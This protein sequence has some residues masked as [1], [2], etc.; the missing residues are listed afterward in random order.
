M[1][2]HPAM[3][4]ATEL[5]EALND[6]GKDQDD[7]IEAVIRVTLTKAL[8][9][10]AEVAGAIADEPTEQRV[11]LDVR[12]VVRERLLAKLSPCNHV[13]V[14]SRTCEHGTDCCTVKHGGP[15]D[16]HDPETCKD[17]AQC[18]V[19]MPLSPDVAAGLEQEIERGTEGPLFREYDRRR[20]LRAMPRPDRYIDVTRAELHADPKAVLDQPPG[21]WVRVRNPDGS[22]SSVMG[23]PH[24]AAVDETDEHAPLRAGKDAI[25][26]RLFEEGQEARVEMDKA[27]AVGNR[28]SYAFNQGRLAAYG[29]AQEIVEEEV[30]AAAVDE[31]DETERMHWTRGYAAAMGAIYRCFHQGDDIRKTMLSDGITIEQME[32]DG[33]QE[34]DLRSIREALGR[35]A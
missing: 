7:V 24:A 30:P 22:V 11:G 8:R 14:S 18:P 28:Y 26:H 17:P 19:C 12:R 20:R 1:D 16:W 35:K 10:A 27:H 29:R 32:A 33:A 25:F 9:W 5:A 23:T 6:D 34:F 15:V 21:T 4:S 13:A 2:N 31:S 3:P